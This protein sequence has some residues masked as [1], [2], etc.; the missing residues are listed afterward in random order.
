MLSSS[1]I[2]NYNLTSSLNFFTNLAFT[3]AFN[4]ARLMS[5]KQS[6]T[7]F[8]S[9]TDCLFNFARAALIYFPNSASTIF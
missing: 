8:S 1:H 2:L 7:T 6:S 5:F 9:M 3:S 4:N